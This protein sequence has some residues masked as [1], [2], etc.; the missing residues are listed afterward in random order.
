MRR[1][2]QLA[3]IYLL[4]IL[5]MLNGCSDSESK[6]NAQ[7]NED[8][9]RQTTL[10][11]KNRANNETPAKYKEASEPNPNDAKAHNS[12]GLIYYKI[13]ALDDAIAE[14]Q[15]ALQL[16]PNNADIHYNLAFVYSLKGEKSQA[17]E[18]LGQA[19]R[20]NPDYV[21]GAQMDPDFSNIRNSE[22]FQTLIENKSKSRSRIRR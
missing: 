15:A 5:A 2:S 16:D 19:I 17:I 3:W 4:I 20:L 11:E 7:S 9:P 10:E 6:T 22:E 1:T 21:R 13:G 14:F 18:H 8:V 12:L